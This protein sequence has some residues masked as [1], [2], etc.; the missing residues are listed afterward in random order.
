M[1]FF[2]KKEKKSYPPHKWKI[3]RKCIDFILESSK[4]TY[5]N[6]FGGFLR[7]DDIKKDTIV[8]VVLIPGTISGDSHA[9]FKMHMLPIDFSVVGS[10]HSH[11]SNVP[12]PSY[13]DLQLFSKHGKVHIIAAAPYNINSWRAFDSNGNELNI[14]VI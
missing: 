9:I 1:G 5:P 10:V 4:S 13:A 8:E 11:P 7:V 6:E 2:K 14:I 12:Y 3:T